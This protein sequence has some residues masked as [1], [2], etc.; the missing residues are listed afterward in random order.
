MGFIST[1]F[2][3]FLIRCWKDGD[4]DGLYRNPESDAL[5][6]KTLA[7]KTRLTLGGLLRAGW[8]EEGGRWS[9]KIGTG[10]FII[11]GVLLKMQP[12]RC[13]TILTELLYILFTVLSNVAS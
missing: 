13:L 7:G 8:A 10:T 3:F 12:F 5:S 9:R 11:H 1:F 4:Q 2:V 6:K